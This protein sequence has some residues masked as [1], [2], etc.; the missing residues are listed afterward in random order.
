MLG[1]TD[2]LDPVEED[3]GEA[4]AVTMVVEVGAA[5]AIA[6]LPWYIVVAPSGA[7]IV[8]EVSKATSALAFLGRVDCG[9]VSPVFLKSGSRQGQG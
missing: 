4:L 1:R 5:V 8:L 3:Q 9:G 7:I 2:V 6:L